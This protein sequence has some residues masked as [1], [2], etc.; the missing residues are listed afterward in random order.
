MAEIKL[1]ADSGGGTSS[2]KGPASSGATPSWRLPSAD[3]S[4]GQY[5][6]TDGS[7]TLSFAKVAG[8]SIAMGSDAAGDVL[9]H[10][11]TDYI[12]LAKGT[13][14]Q[15]LT[16]A[17]GVP[18]WAD[19]AGYDNTPAFS[20]YLSSDQTGIPHDT[21]TAVFFNAEQFDTDS[22]FNTANGT[23]TVP[24][25][26]GGKYQV[27]AQVAFD[28]IDTSGERCEIYLYVDGSKLTDYRQ[29]A[30][31][32]GVVSG[33]LAAA[34]YANVV[35]LDAGQTLQIYA[36]HTDGSAIHLQHEWSFFSAFKLAGV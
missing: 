33:Q 5:L 10:N 6:K 25:G 14:G 11:G 22:A 7:G 21:E 15:V 12:R 9:Y 4:S 17:S 13:D 36:Y 34:A 19:S 30:G 8:T 16:L 28:D 27:N 18:T 1:K 32:W 26:K 29:S 2:L 31:V 24:S 35:Q 20:A 3:G 23:F